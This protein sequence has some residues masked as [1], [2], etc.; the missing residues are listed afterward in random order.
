MPKDRGTPWQLQMRFAH[1]IEKRD[2]IED[3]SESGLDS[4]DD[5]AL[6]KFEEV[7]KSRSAAVERAASGMPLAQ[8]LAASASQAP[9]VA[10]PPTHSVPQP[11]SSTP[12]PHSHTHP[13]PL[14]ISTGTEHTHIIPQNAVIV[15]DC[16]IR[17]LC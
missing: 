15:G 2:V 5:I 13:T 3:G 9:R 14:F 7:A 12:A 1:D 8:L 11:H 16:C 4:G 10:P 17:G 6:R